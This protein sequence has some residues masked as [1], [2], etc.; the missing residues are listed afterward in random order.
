MR[1]SDL[2]E[3]ALRSILANKLRSGLTILGIVI[4][5]TAVISMLSIGEGAKKQLVESFESL[6]SNN[7]MIIPGAIQPGR[8]IVSTG[9]GSAQTLKNDDIDV[10]KN[11]PGILAISPEVQRRFQIVSQEGKNTN[12]LVLG[13]NPEYQIVRN[14]NVE[15][16]SF[17]KESDVRSLAKVA[18]LGSTVAQDL[19]ENEDPIGKIIRINKI[20]FKVIGVLEPKGSLG[21]I[22]FD[23]LIIVPLSTMQKVLVGENYLSMIVVKTESKEVIE[24]VK[25]EVSIAL[26]NKHHV[27]P[28]NPDFSIITPQEFLDT[29]NSLIN[30]MTIFLASIAAISLVVGGIG[31]MN[32]MLTSV[33]ERIKEIGLRKAIGAKKREILLQF[34]FE[35]ILLTLIGGFFGII[36][37]FLLSLVVAKVANI[38][39]YVSLYSIVLAFGFSTLVGLVFG[40]W[41]AKRAAN[42]EPIEALR[43]E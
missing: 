29:F 6:G 1:F 15:S 3:E 9:R 41:P 17:I 19:F 21:Y 38:S 4:G 16:G 26:I 24:R 25:E 8:G 31:I 28:Q 22:N 13:V 11:I 14:V 7:L 36:F 5:I 10:I 12:T 33:T 23:D 2:L 43:Y 40:Y 39:S 32:M 27:D 30:T 37:G 20:P 34:L 35:S 18:V 42:L